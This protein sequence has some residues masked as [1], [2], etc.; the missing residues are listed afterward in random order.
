MR[1][2]FFFSDR[3]RRLPASRAYG[4]AHSRAYA[5]VYDTINTPST[6][7][8]RDSAAR[9]ARLRPRSSGHHLALTT[10][11]LTT[12]SYV[13]AFFAS[14]SAVVQLASMAYTAP[15]RFAAAA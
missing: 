13:S 7:S 11:L 3:P 12:R 9:G 10:K 4:Y 8:K 1:R 15:P 2:R 5:K 6:R 14:K